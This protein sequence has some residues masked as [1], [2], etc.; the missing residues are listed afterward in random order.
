MRYEFTSVPTGERAQQLNIA[1][2]V[3]GLITLH[4][5]QPQYGNFAP[6]F[7]FAWAPGNGDW[8]VRGGF[9]LTAQG[10]IIDPSLLHLL[11][12]MLRLMRRRCRS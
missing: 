7:G 2:S 12:K 11:P 4:A 3:P 9:G 5:P 6:R 10:R 1:A 8:S